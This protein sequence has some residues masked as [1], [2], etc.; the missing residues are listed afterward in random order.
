M[1]TLAC[2]GGPRVLQRDPE[3]AQ[4]PL[5]GLSRL[6]HYILLRIRS[7]TGVTGHDGCPGIDDRFHLVSCDRYRTKRPRF[8]TLFHDKQVHEWRAWWQSLFILGLGIPCEHRD[9]DGVVTVCGNLFQ[10]T[11]TQ[12]IAG[13]LS[14]FHLG[15]PDDRC[16]RCLLKSCNGKDKCNPS[17]G[18][19]RET[20]ETCQHQVVPLGQPLQQVRQ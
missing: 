1:D 13:T 2:I 18:V 14:L 20:R 7:G 9:N 5:R 15:A 16:T 8:P 6:D 11:V 19:G 3:E 10:R 4:T 17:A 12:L